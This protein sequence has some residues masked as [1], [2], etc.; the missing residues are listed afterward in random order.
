[1]YFMT[2]FRFEWLLEGSLCCEFFRF[3]IYENCRL[4]NFIEIILSSWV[5]RLINALKSRLIRFTIMTVQIKTGIRGTPHS[6]KISVSPFRCHF[7]QKYLVYLCVY[8]LQSAWNAKKCGW[9]FFTMQHKNLLIILQNKQWKIC[10][11]FYI[12]CEKIY[13]KIPKKSV[14]LV[15]LFVLLFFELEKLLFIVFGQFSVFVHM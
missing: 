14:W 13:K 7:C 5:R 3:T 4:Q 8:R 11:L 6:A 1:M 15:K 10:C 9:I 2:W 12:I